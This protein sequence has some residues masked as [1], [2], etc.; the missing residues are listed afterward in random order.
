MLK[1]MVAGLG[2]S[3]LMFGFSSSLEMAV[4]VRFVGGL[5][6]GGRDLTQVMATELCEH[7][8]EHQA[9]A[10]STNA[11][12]WGVAVI[13]GPAV[14]GL[15]ARPATNYPGLVAADGF[16]GSYP[17]LPPCIFGSALCLLSLM[18]IAA[19]LPETVGPNKTLMPPVGDGSRRI[20]EAAKGED[21]EEGDG[22]SEVSGL[23]GGGD[24]NEAKGSAADEPD[25]AVLLL[26]E[27]R[28]FFCT[29][30]V[31][32]TIVTIKL[33]QAFYVVGDDNTFP[34]WTAAP[35]EA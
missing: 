24:D 27:Q 29:A 23:L 15:L 3:T 11:A 32:R 17:Y 22:E 6:A 8:P 20:D 4:A 7:C 18:G 25:A 31:T 35:R 10:M 16:W 28:C 12:V 9:R 34:L 14:G 2:V 30:M 5:A 21:E 13:I 19:W 26:R 33:V 1:V